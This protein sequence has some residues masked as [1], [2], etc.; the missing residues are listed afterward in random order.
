M[1]EWTKAHL[2]PMCEHKVPPQ[3]DTKAHDKTQDKRFGIADSPVRQSS[4]TGRSVTTSRRGPQSGTIIAF[5]I[6]LEDRSMRARGGVGRTYAKAKV[7]P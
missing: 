3:Y 2:F 1:L 4:G 5:L 6:Y 7:Y